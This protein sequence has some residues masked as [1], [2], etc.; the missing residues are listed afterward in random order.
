MSLGNW[1]PGGSECSGYR[2]PHPCRSRCHRPKR[3]R[4]MRGQPQFGLSFHLHNRV[5]EF[6]LRSLGPDRCLHFDENNQ[7]LSFLQGRTHKARLAHEKAGQTGDHAIGGAQVGRALASA[8]EDQELMF[9]EHRFGNHRTDAYWH[10]R[11]EHRDDQTK[12]KDQAA[13]HSGNS[14]NVARS[15]QFRQRR[16]SPWIGSTTGI[17]GCS[18]SWRLPSASDSSFG[19]RVLRLGCRRAHRTSSRSSFMNLSRMLPSQ[20]SS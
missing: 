12:E 19:W 8:I 1:S 18:R 11:S 17:S 6:S 5:D 14:I 13:A 10:R 16:N 15:I 7:V 2:E 3:S 9:D 20:S 4:P